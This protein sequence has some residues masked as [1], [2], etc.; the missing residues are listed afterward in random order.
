MDLATLNT[1]IRSLYLMFEEGGFDVSNRAIYRA[2][3]QPLPYAKVVYRHARPLIVLPR[4]VIREP[5]VEHRILATLA[6]AIL[7]GV[8]L[9]EHLR[10]TGNDE[11]VS[12]DITEYILDERNMSQSP[13]PPLPLP[14]PLLT[15][16]ALHA[17]KASDFLKAFE[18]IER[19]VE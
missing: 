5:L 13:N 12:S 11:S 3:S 14:W 19:V 9:R 18:D 6:N 8:A 17:D 15:L 16:T 10:S 4:G 1:Q 7:S 2:D